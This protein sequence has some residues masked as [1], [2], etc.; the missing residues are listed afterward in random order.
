MN[1]LLEKYPVDQLYDTMTKA[2]R[3]EIFLQVIAKLIQ[4]KHPF[5]VYFLDFDNFKEVN[6]TYGHQAGDKCISE[7]AGNIRTMENGRIRGFRY[8]GDE[9]VLIYEN[10]EPDDLEGFA[11]KLRQ[12]IAEKD[13]RHDFS[14]VSDHVTISQG[15]IYGR[16]A[17]DVSPADFLKEADINLYEVKKKMRDSYLISE[18]RDQSRSS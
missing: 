2:F 16:P 1:P 7:V 8:G 10:Y 15:I 5:S 9:F 13:L 3:K 12:S 11:K 4:E 6:D 18:Y 17:A 14:K